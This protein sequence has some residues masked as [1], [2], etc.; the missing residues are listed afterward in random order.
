[1]ASFGRAVLASAIDARYI[2]TTETT[3]AAPS[4]APG[5]LL[6]VPKPLIRAVSVRFNPQYQLHDERHAVFAADI[7]P[8]MPLPASPCKPYALRWVF[9]FDPFMTRE[10]SRM[11]Q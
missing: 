9:Q 10:T 6:F 1:M 3:R 4:A 2:R 7:D 5:Y 8:M 11:K